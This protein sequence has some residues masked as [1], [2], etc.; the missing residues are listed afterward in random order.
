MYILTGGTC[1]HLGYHLHVCV[2]MHVEPAVYSN[3]KILFQTVA[4]LHSQNENHSLGLL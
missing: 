4:I 1:L 3:M 2:C